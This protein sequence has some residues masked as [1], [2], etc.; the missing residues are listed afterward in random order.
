[1]NIP[2]PNFKIDLDLIQGNSS[3]LKP[4]LNEIT[5]TTARRINLRCNF[6]SNIIQIRWELVSSCLFEE[7]KRE[8]YELAAKTMKRDLSFAEGVALI[9]ASKWINKKIFNRNLGSSDN[10]PIFICASL[11]LSIVLNSIGADFLVGVGDRSKLIQRFQ[12]CHV[13]YPGTA[14]LAYS[15]GNP[16]G[17]YGFCGP[18]LDLGSVIHKHFKVLVQW[19]TTCLCISAPRPSWAHCFHLLL[20][21]LFLL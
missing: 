9:Q 1:M 17:L 14:F 13:A 10:W 5:R 8:K 7:L 11:V 16:T 20:I 18:V 6:S 21:S 19:P 12:R 15:L 4:R 3:K 2:D